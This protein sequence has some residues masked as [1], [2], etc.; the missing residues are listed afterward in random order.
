MK[1]FNIIACV[2]CITLHCSLQ[3]QTEVKGVN[4]PKF[5]LYVPEKTEV[6]AWY[7]SIIS[8]KLTASSTLK[9]Q[10][11]Y[12]YEPINASDGQTNTAWVEG[13][14]DYGIGEK[15]E[16]TIEDGSVSSIRSFE[17]KGKVENTYNLPFNPTL[18]FINGVY[19]TDG[20]FKNNSRVKRLKIYH[21]SIYVCDV[22]V[23][24]FRGVQSIDLTSYFDISNMTVL[25]SEEKNA[26]KITLKQLKDKGELPSNYNL[27][28]SGNFKLK[29]GDKI[30]FEI[31][32]VYPGLKWKDTGITEIF[33]K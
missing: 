5:S 17:E 2:S 32:D 14:E 10:G 30:T 18:Y 4:L 8:L 33:C 23:N 29:T 21:N 6:D 3:C 9:P 28:E 7:N 20:S 13:K 1:L 31:A 25:E 22:I 26:K 16:L 24:D 12:N 19:K 11:N 15:L 27:F